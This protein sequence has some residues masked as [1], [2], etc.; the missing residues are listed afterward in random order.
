MDSRTIK[1]RVRILLAFA[2]ITVIVPP[3]AAGIRAA[4]DDWGD[5]EVGE[6]FQ[7]SPDAFEPWAFGSNRLTRDTRQMLK[8]S[9]EYRIEDYARR[10]QLTPE[11]Q[12]KL[13]LAGTGD[14]ERFWDEVEFVREQ[15]LLPRFGGDVTDLND[16][17]ARLKAHLDLVFGTRSLLRRTLATILSD[18]QRRALEESEREWLEAQ[19]VSTAQFLAVILDPPEGKPPQRKALER[20]LLDH[21]P[22]SDTT[23]QYHIYV[24]A[25]YLMRLPEPKRSA[26]LPANLTN[27]FKHLVEA[28]ETIE[29]VLVRYGYIPS[30]E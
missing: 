30:R 14:I 19:R 4:D 18:Y 7:M 28:A 17:R 6:W 24:A 5:E 27:Q 21:L 15:F 29:P 1:R 8:E 25:L 12:D 2:A 11:Q 26:I 16:Q 3:F 10:F 9:L 20:R 23:S 22:P 13:R